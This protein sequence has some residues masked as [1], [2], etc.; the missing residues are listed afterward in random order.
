[1]GGVPEIVG[2]DAPGT[3]IVSRS[4]AEWAA[5]LRSMIDAALLPERVRHYAL[6][7]GWEEVVTQQCALYENV[8]ERW[9][10]DFRRS[11][12]EVA[13]TRA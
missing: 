6:Q 5:A 1:V 4:A 13:D 10:S 12:L 9:V 2:S 3:M 7:F 11:G 8:S